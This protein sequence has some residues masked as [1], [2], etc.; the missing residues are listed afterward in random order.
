MN[1]EIPVLPFSNLEFLN[2]L[3]IHVHAN[4]DVMKKGLD[5]DGDQPPSLLRPDCWSQILPVKMHANFSL[6]KPFYCCNKFNMS[7]TIS[8]L[9]SCSTGLLFV[10]QRKLNS[11]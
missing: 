10:N 11:H 3:S 6:S 4:D 8:T 7:K 2:Q 5:P 1:S 9:R